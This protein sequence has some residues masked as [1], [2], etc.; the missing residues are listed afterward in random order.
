MRYVFDGVLY[1]MCEVIQR[2]NAP[3]IALAMVFGV[4]NAVNYGIA[5]IDVGRSH[6]YFCPQHQRSVAH[7]SV[8]HVVKQLQ[9][10][11]YRAVAVFAFHAR[12][13]KSAAHFLHLFGRHV[14]DVSLAL[15]DELDGALVHSVEII[16]R[17]IHVALPAQPFDVGDNGPD[18]LVVFLYGIGVV[19]A[20]VALAAVFK[21]RSVIVKTDGLGVS[22]VQIAVGFGRKTGNDAAYSALGQ[23]FFYNLFNKIGH[24]LPP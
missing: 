13:R 24:K 5:H 4:Q 21:R 11:L 12:L 2:I 17:I 16:G 20:Q 18:K 3:L 6:V 23:I 10:L 14:V 9:T 1:R 22:Y 19:K 8:F 15:F 7:Q